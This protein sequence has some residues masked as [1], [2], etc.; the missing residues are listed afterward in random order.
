MSITHSFSLTEALSLDLLGTLS[1]AGAYY[2]ETNYGSDAGSALTHAQLDA[3]LNYAV[4]E[5]FSVGLKG[6]FSSIL[7][8]DVRDDI[9]EGDVYPE[10]DIFFGGVTASYSF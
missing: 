1:Y 9:D 7:D 6:S 5:A 3:G 10:T 2:V 8:S 4:S